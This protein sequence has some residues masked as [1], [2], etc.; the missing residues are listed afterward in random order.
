MDRACGTHRTDKNACKSF[1]GK[2]DRRRALGR[3]RR[4]LENNIRIDLRKIMWEDVDWIHLAQD[5]KY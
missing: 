5:R 2:F 4:R 1:V 3:A